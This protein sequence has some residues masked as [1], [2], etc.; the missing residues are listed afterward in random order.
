MDEIN[1][2]HSSERPGAVPKVIRLH[3]RGLK[4]GQVKIA[5]RRVF[6]VHQMLASL[7]TTATARKHQR[8]IV[9]IV[10]VAVAQA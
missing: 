3:A 4:H 9:R 1:L 5:Q 7:E 10:T 8:Q 6:L 2:R